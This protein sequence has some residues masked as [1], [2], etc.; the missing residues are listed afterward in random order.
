MII[1]LYPVP[2]HIFVCFIGCL[3]PPVRWHE[4]HWYATWS[5]ASNPA[6][7]TP[8]EVDRTKYVAGVIFIHPLFV[9]RAKMV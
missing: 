3:A 9:G 4:R 7:A 5:R 8:R 1:S 6:I 2:E